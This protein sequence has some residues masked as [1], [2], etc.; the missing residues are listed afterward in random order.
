METWLVALILIAASA[1]GT[2]LIG[3]AMLRGR[4]KT[5]ALKSFAAERGL[6]FEEETGQ[7]TRTI[8]RDPSEGWQ[9]VT[10]RTE[11]GPES[12]SR[13][14]WS[15]F[16]DPRPTQE[17]GLTV[18][19]PSLP[20]KAA[21]RAD[22]IMSMAGGMIGNVMIANIT[23]GM[24]DE[25][26]TLAVVEGK[27]RPHEGLYLATPGAEAGLTAIVGD[28][29]LQATRVAKNEMQQPIVLRGPDGLRVR[30]RHAVSDP[31]EIERLVALGRHLTEKLLAEAP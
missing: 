5:E 24:G 15:E 2:G 9:F 31:Q 25:A 13:T 22:T 30:V 26:K 12:S 27:S 11:S 3:Y 8:I 1:L 14:V 4:A 6:V 21:A 10:Y 20:E 17:S 19:G 18:L 16:V 7:G 23:K 28:A 29:E